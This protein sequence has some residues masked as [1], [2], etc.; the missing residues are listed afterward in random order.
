[1][2]EQ[3]ETVRATSHQNRQYGDVL[4]QGIGTVHGRADIGEAVWMS[5]D[6]EGD[7]L[8]YR[9]SIKWLNM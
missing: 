9:I 1:M 5:L 4:G 7:Y 6:D 2:E 8:F 3:K